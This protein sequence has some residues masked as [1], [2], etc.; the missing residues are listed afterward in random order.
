ML[1]R[2]LS[3]I[4]QH[5]LLHL[6]LIAMSSPTYSDDNIVMPPYGE[7]HPDAAVTIVLI[8]GGMSCGHDDWKDAIS[9]LSDYHLLVPDLPG[10]GSARQPD[11]HPSISIFSLGAATATLSLLIRRKAKAGRAHIVAFSI[12]AHVAVHL[13]PRHPELILD[14]FLTGYN[15][16]PYVN[17]R[18][19]ASM[20][21]FSHW[22]QAAV[23]RIAS[24]RTATPP[25]TRSPDTSLAAWHRIADT[26]CNDEWP[27]PWLA[28]TL[29]VAVGRPGFPQFGDS[30]AVALR[31]GSIG[32]QANPQTTAY[33]SEDLTHAWPVQHPELF[34]TAVKEWFH[35]STVPSFLRCLEG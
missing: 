3:N 16:F 2:P 20:F 1:R 31:L 28:K 34:A 33:G 6:C 30:P 32:Q 18:F 27:Q 25:S 17:A 5:A 7:H 26:L 8:H 19:L 23:S 21:W 9:H 22:C 29:I 24:C 11:A 12:G 14:A 35:Q 15:F 4:V 13:V 10:H